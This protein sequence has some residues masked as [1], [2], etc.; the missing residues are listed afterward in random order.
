MKVAGRI[1]DESADRLTRKHQLLIALSLPEDSRRW[2]AGNATLLGGKGGV[3]RKEMSF[4]DL[5]L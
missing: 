2:I 1:D 5:H 4:E 3:E